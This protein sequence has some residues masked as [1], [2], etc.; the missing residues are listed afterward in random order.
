MMGD[1]GVKAS[2]LGG[3]GGD[4]GTQ[5]DK[6]APTVS[7]STEEASATARREYRDA[8]DRLNRV[9]DSEIDAADRARWVW[10]PEERIAV[11]EAEVRRLRAMLVALGHEDDLR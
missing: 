8:V 2:W 9:T 6:S 1:C 11:L 7:G 10:T 5:P 3:V 4:V